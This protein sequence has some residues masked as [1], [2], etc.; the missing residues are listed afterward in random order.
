MLTPDPDLQSLL[1]IMGV[2]AFA[3]SGGVVAVRAGLDLFG[4]LVL[5]WV[6]GLGGG[7]VRDLLIGQ[8]P[9][10][11]ISNGPLMLTA[12]LSG[13]LVFLLQD[14]LDRREAR[15]GLRRVTRVVRVL[16]AIGLS[17]FAVAGTLKALGLGIDALPAVVVGVITAVGGGVIRD[18]LV[19][20]IP[21][22]LR[23]ELYAIP[24]MLGATAIA[25][26]HHY[27][28]LHPLVIWTV[29]LFTFTLRMIAIR[30]NLNAPSALR[31]TALRGRRSSARGQQPDAG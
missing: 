27:N 22:V 16:D 21:E 31:S 19:G 15:P 20:Q 5:A 17:T 2:F 13:L 25:I 9:P 30:L 18:V 10:V 23:R 4:V 7:I 24:A 14:L 3:L 26:A 29:V 6:T 11:G 1:D 8:T 28:A 12:V